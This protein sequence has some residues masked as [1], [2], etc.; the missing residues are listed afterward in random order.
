VHEAESAANQALFREANEGIRA[1]VDRPDVILPLVPFVCECSD[2]SCR[3]LLN[4]PLA[5]YERV[6]SSP[7]Q[8]LH[9]LEH[10]DDGTRG[11]VVET[12]DG[13][14]VVEKT[15]LSAEVAEGPAQGGD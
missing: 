3:R 1:V 7:R 14:A 11:R 6:R 12:S 5:V 9:A 15:G 10:I 13:F 2:L 8:F 4:V